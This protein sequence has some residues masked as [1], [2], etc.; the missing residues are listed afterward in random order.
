M[1][2]FSKNLIYIALPLACHVSIAG[3][4]LVHFKEG[5][6]LIDEHNRKVLE[7]IASLPEEFSPAQIIAAYQSI[8]P[9]LAALKKQIVACNGQYKALRKEGDAYPTEEISIHRYKQKYMYYTALLILEGKRCTP[10][11]APIKLPFILSSFSDMQL[12]HEDTDKR[13]Q[14]LWSQAKAELHGA[15]DILQTIQNEES[16]QYSSIDFLNKVL[17]YF[18][19]IRLYELYLEEDREGASKTA[20]LIS[21]EHPVI[22]DALKKELL[23]LKEA[24]YYGIESLSE[25]LRLPAFTEPQ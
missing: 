20:A 21:K 11:G 13:T 12:L 14:E 25:I 1:Y 3:E 23:R 8:S 24:N 4:A 22:I 18:E 6:K 16:A 19:C 17:C 15:I 7:V 10:K 2:L 9:E 5:M